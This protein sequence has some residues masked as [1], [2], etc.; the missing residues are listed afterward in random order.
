MPIKPTLI[1]S[2]C[3]LFFM[4][5]SAEVHAKKYPIETIAPKIQMIR[6]VVGPIRTNSYIVWETTS[7]HAIVIDPGAEA[8][9]I[10]QIIKS[11]GLELKAIVHTHHH[12]DHTGDSLKLQQLTNAPVFE[13]PE[14]AKRH[15][16]FQKLKSK[17]LPHKSKQRFGK[18]EFEIIHTPGHSPGGVCLYHKGVLFSGDLLFK[19]SIGRV[20]L[21]GGSMKALKNSIRQRLAHLPDET[22]VFPGHKAATTLK[23]ERNYNRI[24]R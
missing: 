5:M 10:H 8:E 4:L 14:C 18:L 11:G 17:P 7:K 22:K 19:R 20:D 9:E 12:W 23:Q 3:L 21:P 24:F 13:H 1:L 2:F 16:H 15:K 6:L